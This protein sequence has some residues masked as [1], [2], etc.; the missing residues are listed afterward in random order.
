MRCELRT[1]TS[2][3]SLG[4]TAKYLRASESVPEREDAKIQLVTVEQGRWLHK[5]NAAYRHLKPMP[6]AQRQRRLI[7]TQS[8]E[9]S[10]LSG[11]TRQKLNGR[12]AVFETV[13]CR[14]DSC[15]VYASVMELEY[16]LVL[17]TKFC[18]FDSRQMYGR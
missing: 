15:L 16:I 14:F 4:E 17:E 12:A 7:Q 10:N 5:Q 8:S 18:E 3:L 2:Q 1:E 6:L 11:H 13:G 9:S